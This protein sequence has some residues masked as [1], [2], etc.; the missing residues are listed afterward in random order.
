MVDVLSG[1]GFLTDVH[2]PYDPVDRSR[3]GHL[4]I[5]LNVA[6]F[7]PLDA[8]NMEAYIDALKSAPVA[9]DVDEVFYPG[10]KEVRAHERQLQEGLLLPADT[11]AGLDEV[12][13]Q[14]GVKP[15]ERHAA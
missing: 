5:A 12:A 10:E 4:M 14:S 2:G 6:A 13:A 1:S 15:V 3:A 11:F 7:Q 9:E 8:F